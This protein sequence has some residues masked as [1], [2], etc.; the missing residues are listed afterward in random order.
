MKG[1]NHG[2]VSRKHFTVGNIRNRTGYHPR[3]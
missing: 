1:D 2:L 3:Y